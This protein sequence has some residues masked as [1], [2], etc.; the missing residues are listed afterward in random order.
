MCLVVG[1]KFPDFP[2]QDVSRIDDSCFTKCVGVNYAQ[3][4]YPAMGSCGRTMTAVYTEKGTYAFCGC[5]S[6]EL[7][8]FTHSML[9]GNQN[10]RE[11]RMEALNL[12]ISILKNQE[13]KFKKQPNQ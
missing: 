12:L 1:C 2:W 8:N 3:V 6:G 9:Y 10:L 11:S 13:G 5:T 4:T 7:H